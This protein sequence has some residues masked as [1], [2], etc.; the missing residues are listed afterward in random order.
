MLFRD[1]KQVD[2]LW[3]DMTGALS[4]GTVISLF[5]ALL[6][7][8]G[9]DSVVQTDPYGLDP[10]D[11]MRGPDKGESLKPGYSKLVINESVIPDTGVNPVL[12]GL[13]LI[14]MG[15]FNSKERTRDD[16]EKLLDAA[17]FRIVREYT[18]WTAMKACKTNHDCVAKVRS[19]LE[20]RGFVDHGSDD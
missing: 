11:S 12:S 2:A 17:G 19:N 18:D 7:D 6:D 9:Q 3:S 4:G 15:V 14:M 10:P 5:G 13:D 16:W 1:T 8:H 20:E